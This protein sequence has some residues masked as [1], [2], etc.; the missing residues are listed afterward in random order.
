MLTWCDD[1]AS[2]PAWH[3]LEIERV[4]ADLRTTPQGLTD[5]DAAARLTTIGPNRIPSQPGV[6]ALVI[7]GNQLRSVVVRWFCSAGRGC[8]P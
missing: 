5:P 3:A 6:S 1:A 4:R 2:R 7:L 8:A